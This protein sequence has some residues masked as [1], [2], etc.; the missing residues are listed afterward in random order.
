MPWENKNQSLTEDNRNG[1]FT[2]LEYKS[3]VKELKENDYIFAEFNETEKLLS[4]NRPFVLMRHDVDMDIGLALEMARIESELRIQSTFFFLL[5]TDHYNV[6][7][8]EGSSAV[9]KIL[10]LGHHLGLHF[11]CAS[12]PKDLNEE[13]LARAC[14]QEAD[15]L[16]RWFS[17]QIKIVSFHRPN[18]IVLKG[19][20][21]I[22]SPRKH[23]YMPLYTESIKYVSDSTGKWRYGF[24]T[25]I[26]EFKNKAP[27]HILTHPIWWNK[28]PLSEQKALQNFLEKKGSE[29]KDS[30]AT[31]CKVF[32]V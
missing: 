16:E 11:D 15:I 19:D 31:N 3:M 28:E 20:P 10:G 22:S 6:F 25:K 27:L 32:K 18:D 12:Y 13:E 1:D 9:N 7:S 8:K 30:L 26:E 14:S 4:E 5:S 23:T 17:K 21:S 24:P 2:Y 29:L